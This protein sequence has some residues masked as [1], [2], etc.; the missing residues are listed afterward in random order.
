MAVDNPD[1]RLQDAVRLAFLVAGAPPHLDYAQDYDHSEE[2]MEA[3]RLGNCKVTGMGLSFWRSEESY[4]R[5]TDPRSGD[6]FR[7]GGI[8]EFC[9]RPEQR[10]SR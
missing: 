1:W 5:R 2:M 6:M 9:S 7:K 8:Q 4:A 3:N 10:A